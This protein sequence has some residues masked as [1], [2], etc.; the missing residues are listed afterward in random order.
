[1][2]MNSSTKKPGLVSI[3]GIDVTQFV[4]S[5][6]FGALEQAAPTVFGLPV[7]SADDAVF[8]PA[9]GEIVLGIWDDRETCYACRQSFTP[10]PE[11]VA[12]ARDAS[13]EYI[14]AV[15]PVCFTAMVAP[16]E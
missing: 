9:R 7:V 6:D 5:I 1:M 11:G 4:E 10:G 2:A 16:H 13:G 12:V 15:C 8:E 14:G 3:N